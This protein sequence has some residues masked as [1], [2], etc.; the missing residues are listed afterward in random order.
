MFSP[1]MKTDKKTLHS[2]TPG[3]LGNETGKGRTRPPSRSKEGRAIIVFGSEG[4]GKQKKIFPPSAE[5]EEE[6][7][8]E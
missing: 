6:D 7:M 5:E 1:F 2:F 3:H 8:W 4:G